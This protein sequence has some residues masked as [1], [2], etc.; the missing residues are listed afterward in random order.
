MPV[1][2]ISS[3]VENMYNK[4]LPQYDNQ[5]I[6][7]NRAFTPNQPIIKPCM[8]INYYS[9]PGTSTSQVKRL[10]KWTLG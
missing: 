8:C 5:N 3:Y 4:Y 2:F 7:C 10:A 1:S 6:Y 9:K